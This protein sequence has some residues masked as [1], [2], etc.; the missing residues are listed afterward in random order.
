MTRV[1][2]LTDAEATSIAEDIGRIWFGLTGSPRIPPIEDRINL[3]QRVTRQAL[4]V[5]ASRPAEA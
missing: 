2:V 4:E 5:V 3:V 1:T